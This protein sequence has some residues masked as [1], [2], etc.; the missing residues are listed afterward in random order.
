MVKKINISSALSFSF[1]SLI[2]FF[3]YSSYAAD[4]DEEI[5]VEEITVV[6]TTPG[7]GL[8]Q[9]V[10]KIPFAVQTATAGDLENAQSLDLSEFMNNS[11]SS[12][13]IN[14]AQN[15]PLQPD[16]QFRG[17][18][19]SPLLGLPQGIA[20]YQN[21]VRINEPL[22]DSVNWDL[23][24]ESAVSSIDMISGANPLFGLN[25]LGGALVINMKDGFNFTGHQAE[26][27]TGSWGRIVVNLESGGNTRGKFGQWGYYLNLSSFK[28]DG[29]RQLSGS[30]ALNFYSSGSWRNG[31]ISALNL[32]FQKGDS[33]LRGNGPAPVGLLAIQ[34]DAVFTGPD[35]TENDMQMFSIDG[36]HFLGP[37]IQIAGTAF[38]RQNS[39]DSFNGDSSDFEECE[40]FGA[41]RSLF[42]DAGEVEENLAILLNIELDTICTGADPAIT[43]FPELEELIGTRAELAGLDAEDFELDD[44]LENLSGSGIISDE[45]INNISGR[46]QQTSG[47]DG[48]LIVLSDLF[49]KDNRLVVGF[50]FFRGESKFNSVLELAELDPVTR[51]SEGLGTGTFLDEAAT[52]INAETET[53]SLFFTDTLEVSGRLAITVSGRYNYSDISLRDRSGDRPELNGDHNFSRF[54]PSLGFTFAAKVNTNIYGSYSESNRIPTPIELAC[55]EGVFE[56]AQQFAIIEGE[57]PTDVEFECRLPNAFLADPPLNDVVTKN[58]ELG[59]R[60]KYANINYQLGFFHALNRDDILFQ[61]TGRST[62]LFANVDEIKRVG[63]E[64]AVNGSVDKLDWYA[65]YSHIRATFEDDFTVLSP[66]HPSAD[67]NGVIVVQSGDR[68]PGIPETLFKIGGD[69]H[70]SDSLS[71]GIGAIYNS[72]QIFRGDESN[73]LEKVD[74]YTVVNL[75]ASYSFEEWFT[76]FARVTNIFDKEYE[77]F[78]LLGE[79]PDEVLKNLADNRPL[80]LGAGAPR[81][82]WLG[83]RFKF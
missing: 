43:S 47:F 13:S 32:N 59:M 67:E 34:R 37:A 6:G 83:I 41:N 63:F 53:W 66:N 62:G 11:L 80:F 7:S 69:Y 12:V 18:T 33:N 9:D 61:T 40:Y 25:T 46:K 24:P 48:K 81:A 73:E 14:A 51:S 60:G 58:I 64:S 50:S 57:D 76:V 82:A 45:A 74:G 26:V 77:N 71:M 23:L 2:L 3:P 22:G 4:L 75:R 78:G 35:I 20:V 65:S 19:A 49:E 17:F 36:S 42:D 70:F 44:L 38:W 29:W 10:N 28:E 1:F 8:E 5:P 39:T 27:Y 68:L 21:G 72:S 56:L 31:E 79:E 16:V 30:E 52:S 55:N 15:N 54:N